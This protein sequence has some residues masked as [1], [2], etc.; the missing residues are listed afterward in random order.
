MT[1]DEFINRALTRDEN[2]IKEMFSHAARNYDRLNHWLSFNM[3]KGW[4]RAMVKR[5][6]LGSMEGDVLLLDLCT[7]TGDVVFEFVRNR[8][9]RGKAVGIDFAEPML[10][11]AREKA[12]RMH[13]EDKV[14]F[15]EANALDLPFEEN[16]FHLVTISFGLRN[17]SNLDKGIIEI[18]RVLKPG[19]CFLSLEFFHPDDGM[20]K[21]ISSWYINYVVPLV[22][23]MVNKRKGAYAYLS[24]SRDKFIDAGGLDVKLRKAGFANVN[25]RNFLFRI[26]TLHRCEKPK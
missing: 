23:N 16:S 21:A 10:K 7:G 2:T 19:G 24:A 26:A 15:L 22:G 14:T 5:A 13:V 8:K 17:L 25:H 11:I 4:R 9:F 3:D 12:E 18:K 20:S 6:E 1:K